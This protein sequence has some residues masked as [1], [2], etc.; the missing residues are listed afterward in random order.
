MIGWIMTG[1]LLLVVARIVWAEVKC[2][3]KSHDFLSKINQDITTLHS[4]A[5]TTYRSKF[6]RDPDRSGDAP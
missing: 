5:T 4:Q 1:V 3:R 6:G 2:G